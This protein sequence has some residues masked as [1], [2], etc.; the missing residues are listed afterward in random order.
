MLWH[1][2]SYDLRKMTTF[3]VLEVRFFQRVCFS[4]VQGPDP[5]PVFRW[6]PLTLEELVK[7]YTCKNPV[8]FYFKNMLRN[9]VPFVQS[10]NVKS[11]HGWVL[12]L[13]ELQALEC[14]ARFGTICAVW[15]TRTFV[16]FFKLYKWYQRRNAYNLLFTKI[17][18][19]C[20]SK[21]FKDPA[22]CLWQK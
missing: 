13:V 4:Q 9:S 6:C 1:C 11:T 5:G 3:L 7:L 12:L 14:V 10:K 21:A 17:I 22:K 20:I 2:L 18:L 16:T 8:L 15:K 19:T